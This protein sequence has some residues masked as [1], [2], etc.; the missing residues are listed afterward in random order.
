MFFAVFY[1]LLSGFESEQ[2]TGFVG[3]FKD[4]YLFIRGFYP[5][6]PDY[7]MPLAI[8]LA[9]AVSGIA[10]INLK[11]RFS[12][13]VP[14]LFGGALVMLPV[15]MDYYRTNQPVYIF[16]FCFLVFLVKRL[17]EGA[18]PREFCN[19]F[20]LRLIPLCAGLV[21]VMSLMPVPE[22]KS[23]AGGRLAGDDFGGVLGDF[24][25]EATHPKFFSFQTTGFTD[26]DGK[27]GGKVMA[28]GNFVMD[29]YADERVYLSGAVKDLYTGESWENTMGEKEAIKDDKDRNFEL[30]NGFYNAYNTQG[31]TKRILIFLGGARTATVFTPPYTK[32]ARFSSEVEL[33]RDGAGSLSVKDLLHSGADYRIEYADVNRGY[34]RRSNELTNQTY[35][36]NIGYADKEMQLYKDAGMGYFGLLYGRGFRRRPSDIPQDGQRYIP[37]YVTVAGVTVEAGRLYDEGFLPNGADMTQGEPSYEDVYITNAWDALEDGQFFG[38]P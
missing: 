36:I 27:L 11:L 15:L 30:T 20:D 16:S 13:F 3:F 21:F 8:I 18:E 28:T 1:F 35:I 37:V 2:F 19:M 17:N 4:M 23:T 34:I 26:K 24:L 32:A 31:E 9:L 5:Y 6:S 29:V 7:D 12:F 10:V 38:V 14:A 33:Y 25:Y 22:M